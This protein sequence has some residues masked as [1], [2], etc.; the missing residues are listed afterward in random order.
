MIV[1]ILLILFALS[2]A[3]LCFSQSDEAKDYLSVPGPLQFN[4]I[5]F[6]LAWSSHP[7]QKYYKQEY[8]PEGQSVERYDEMMLVEVLTGSVTAADAATSKMNELKQRKNRDQFV[9]YEIIHDPKTG[10]Y[11]LDF[12]LSDTGNEQ[13]QIVEWNAYRYVE[14]DKVSQS[15]GVMLIAYSRRAYGE[16]IRGFLNGLSSQRTADIEKLSKLNVPDIVLSE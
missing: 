7:D 12:S 16:E 9:N 3:S 8:V 15:T 10:Q 13:A 2:S 6:K 4:G 5:D 14:L 11:I 1:R